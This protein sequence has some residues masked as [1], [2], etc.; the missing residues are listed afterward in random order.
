MKDVRLLFY[1]DGA[2]DDIF[3]EIDPVMDAYIH[4][5]LDAIG[6]MSMYKDLMTFWSIIL[7]VLP[8]GGIQ[9]KFANGIGICAIGFSKESSLE[10]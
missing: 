1:A 6:L 3:M 4:E 7:E 5:A 8:L 9:D 2:Y 10:V